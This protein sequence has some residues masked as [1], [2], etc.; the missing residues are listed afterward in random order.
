MQILALKIA[1]VMGDLYNGMDWIV[2]GVAQVVA[3]AIA[4]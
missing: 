3:K 4:G 1:A 2:R